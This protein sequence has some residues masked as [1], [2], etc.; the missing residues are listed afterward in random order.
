LTV[1]CIFEIIFAGMPGDET[2]L[3]MLAMRTA[4]MLMLPDASTSMPVT[5]ANRSLTSV[6]SSSS[7]AA[8]LNRQC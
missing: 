2:E 8:A 1:L 5:T 4:L 7:S 3:R 6:S